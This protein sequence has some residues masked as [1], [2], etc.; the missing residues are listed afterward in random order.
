MKNPR[1][2][3]TE[4]EEQLKKAKQEI[5]ALEK[6]LA[7]CETSRREYALAVED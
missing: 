4:L 2:R 6:R 1:I 3:V 5:R 7:E